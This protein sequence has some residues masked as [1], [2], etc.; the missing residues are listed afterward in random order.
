MAELDVQRNKRLLWPWIAALL[1]LV[2]SAWLA[3]SVMVDEDELA[4]A[5][6]VGPV[7]V[8]AAPAVEVAPPVAETPVPVAQAAGIPVS[9]IISSPATWTGRTLGGEVRVVEVVSD[10]GFW[11][12]DQ[13]QR[14]F[15]VLNESG[16]DATPD[17]QAGQSVRL[18]E[19]VVY[20]GSD[21]GAVPGTLEPQARQVAQAQPVVLAVDARNVAMVPAGP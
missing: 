12:E 9:E 20:A 2:A 13:G 4:V 16:G 19:A 10:R 11:I 17:L 18:T 8:G 14:L 1:V 15:V 7:L 21:P 3:W 6:P 5:E